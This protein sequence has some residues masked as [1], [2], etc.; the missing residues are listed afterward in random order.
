MAFRY[1]IPGVSPFRS[2]RPAMELGRRI[3]YLRNVG[4]SEGVAIH[5]A[6][7]PDAAG[8]DVEVTFPIWEEARGG[9]GRRWAMTLA[10][11]IDEYEAARHAAF[12]GP[13]EG[14]EAMRPIYAAYDAAVERLARALGRLR[15]GYVRHGNRVYS[16]GPGFA[17]SWRVDWCE[18]NDLPADQIAID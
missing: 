11:A 9:G 12:D 10:D 6:V 3:D 18:L 7:T 4:H 1:E 15:P 17:G 13:R 5:V 8:F 16:G 2:A 14:Y